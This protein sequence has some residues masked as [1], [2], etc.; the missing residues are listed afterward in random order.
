MASGW[1]PFAWQGI[2]IETPR[3]W[4]L[5]AVTGDRRKGYF[6]LDDAEMPRLEARWQAGTTRDSVQ[7]VADHYLKKAGLAG[8]KA[9]QNVER[10]VRLARPAGVE[11]EFFVTRGDPTAVHM[12]A[13]CRDCR[14]IALL[15]VFRRPDESLQ[16]VLT[17]LFDSYRDHA[18][19]G[20]M[21]WSLFGLRFQVPEKYA[22]IRH[23]I[24]AGRVELEYAGKRVRALAARVGLAETVL[25]KSSLLD[26]VKKDST[27]PWPACDP[28]FAETRRGEHA[29]I[30]VTGRERSLARRM[31]GRRRVARGLV[32]HCEP[33][34]ALYV[35]R[36]LG[37]EE[38]VPE[39]AAFTESFLCH[40]P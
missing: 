29:A 19:G 20:K 8:A 5:G 30:A 33:S 2:Q 24:R 12:A 22:L 11:A 28:D 3:D 7:A 40:E 37:R 31:L 26:W 32:W 15:R 4:E 34:N 39:F 17:R 6:R 36:W 38:A 1:S 23:S 18:R 10:N 16:P 21:P 35:A 9:G 13:R 27:G 25:R 14:R